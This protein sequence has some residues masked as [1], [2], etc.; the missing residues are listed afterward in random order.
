MIRG[1]SEYLEAPLKAVLD[2]CD[3]IDTLAKRRIELLLDYDHHKR[4]H[5]ALAVRA[6]FDALDHTTPDAVACGH[7]RRN[8]IQVCVS[9]FPGIERH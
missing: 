8:D 6:V 1:L 2:F 9:H 5:D 4:K 3:G 7:K